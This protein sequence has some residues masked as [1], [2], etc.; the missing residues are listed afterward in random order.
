LSHR[1]AALHAFCT[2]PVYHVK[3]MSDAYTDDVYSGIVK[4]VGENLIVDCPAVLAWYGVDAKL[5]QAQKPEGVTVG[6]SVNFSCGVTAKGIPIVTWAEKVAKPKQE[7]RKREAEGSA[8]PDEGAEMYQ[9]KIVSQS[10]KDP[11][12]YLVECPVVTEWFKGTP[13]KVSGEMLFL[14][15]AG[16]GDKIHFTLTEGDKPVVAWCKR[17]GDGPKKQKADAAVAKKAV[18]AAAEEAPAP[19]V[20]KAAPATAAQTGA[21]SDDLTALK[22]QLNAEKTARLEAQLEAERAKAAAQKAELESLRAGGG[23][24]AANSS[25]LHRLPSEDLTPAPREEQSSYKGG[26]GKG[27]GD[28]GKGK[29]KGE[30]KGKGDGKGDGK[31]KGKGKKGS[32][33]AEVRFSNADEAEEALA[34]YNTSLPDWPGRSLKV[35]LDVKCKDG[36]RVKVT[37]LPAGVPDTAVR[38]HLS[39]CGKITNLSVFADASTTAS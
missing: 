18:P 21:V 6:D 1:A 19:V 7:K 9:G 35:Q 33:V 2:D 30:G 37:G 5:R 28:K 24:G 8:Q 13:A 32:S 22:E 31:S 36:T 34:L 14:S 39:Q 25:P 4:K 20:Q 38:K 17:V 10:T 3:A 23:L 27:K 15:N 26:G 29:G 12:M 16:M 11:T